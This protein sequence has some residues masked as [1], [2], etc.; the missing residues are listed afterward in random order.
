MS[1]YVDQTRDVE[2]LVIH[3]ISQLYRI[4]HASDVGASDSLEMLVPR[5]AAHERHTIYLAAY[6]FAAFAI[7]R[8]RI[9]LVGIAYLR[10]LA[11]SADIQSSEVDE[12]LLSHGQIC[13]DII[14]SDAD[15]DI[16]SALVVDDDTLAEV[17]S[18]IVGYD[19]T[20]DLD[21]VLDELHTI[22]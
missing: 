15:L 10:S 18:L 12:Y 2:R 8:T 3:G 6:D 14:V 1:V 7:H 21:F 5:V 13:H 20:L 16:L 11:I 4:G 19:D 17:A 22:V 9:L